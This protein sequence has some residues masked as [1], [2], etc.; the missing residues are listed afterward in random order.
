MG[1]LLR[2]VT[3]GRSIRTL[4]LSHGGHCSSVT[5]GG[6]DAVPGGKRNEPKNTPRLCEFGTLV[7]CDYESTNR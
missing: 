7:M 4:A 2:W 3:L 6:G 1:S 5:W